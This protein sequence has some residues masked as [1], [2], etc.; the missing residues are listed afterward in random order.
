MS[1]LGMGGDFLGIQAPPLFTPFMILFCCCHDDVT[2]HRR[3]CHLVCRWRCKEVKG[4][5]VVTLEA[6]LE[7]TTFG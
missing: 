5:L 4:S 3:E 2:H 1:V 7:P 6:L